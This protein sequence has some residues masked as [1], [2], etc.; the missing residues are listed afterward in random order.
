MYDIC[1]GLGLGFYIFRGSNT[2]W[3]IAKDQ[4][5]KYEHL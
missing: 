3:H 2:K 4:K 5:S 1:S